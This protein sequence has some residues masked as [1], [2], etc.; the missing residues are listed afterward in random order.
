MYITYYITLVY[1]NLVPILGN[2][3]EFEG[4]YIFGGGGGGGGRRE[5]ERERESNGSSSFIRLRKHTRLYCPKNSKSMAVSA[6][7]QWRA[8]CYIDIS[9][10]LLF[11]QHG[12]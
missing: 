12:A 8:V 4:P 6:V 9:I 7:S 11:L 2:W 10:R 1:Y 3:V 5:R